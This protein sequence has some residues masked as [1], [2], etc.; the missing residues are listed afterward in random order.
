M[1]FQTL[2]P[3]YNGGR[4]L[5]HLFAIGRRSDSALLKRELALRFVAG[6]VVLYSRGRSALAAA[7]R[8]L[9]PEGKKQVAMSGLTCFSVE[10]AVTATGGMDTP[11]LNHSLIDKSP[12]ENATPRKMPI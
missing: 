2:A 7:I 5:R 1:L 12:K 9:M 10:Q 8:Q 4:A 6:H 3:E 11:N